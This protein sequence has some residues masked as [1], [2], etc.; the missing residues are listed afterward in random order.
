MNGAQDMGGMHGFGPV[1]PEP[2][3]PVFHETWEARVLALT[4]AMGAAG[5]WNIDQGRF[6]REDRPPADYLSKTYYQVWLA[7][8]ERLLDEHG[9][10]ERPPGRVLRAEDVPTALA[11]VRG[12]DREPPGPARFAV[13][14]RVRTRNLNPP[15]HTR[16]PRY[17]RDK[18]GTVMLVHGAH[19]F[20][21]SSAQGKG[22]DPQ[23]LYTVRF[24]ARDL[25]GPD[26][27]PKQ[28][29]SIDAWEPYLD[30]A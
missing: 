16:L 25:F 29:T 6:A 12:S 20:P 11:T 5:E 18:L 14:D 7:G 19:V 15:T 8:L 23:W 22:E 28:S 27:D 1:M 4:V 17:A 13:G 30:P 26:A 2:D 9:V 3:E 21:D 24:S 10:L